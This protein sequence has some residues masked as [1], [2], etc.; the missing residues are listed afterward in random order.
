MREKL[1]ELQMKVLACLAD[2]YEDGE[3]PTYDEE[4]RMYTFKTIAKDVKIT[5]REARLATRALKRKGL[6][7]YSV[8]WKNEDFEKIHGSGHGITRKGAELFDILN[9]KQ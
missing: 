2:G 9:K 4:V 6:A 1:S 3:F 7:M 5:E 8:V